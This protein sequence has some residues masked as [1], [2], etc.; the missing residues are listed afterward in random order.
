MPDEAPSMEELAVSARDLLER[1]NREGLG[2]GST[3]ALTR[4]LLRPQEGDYAKAFVPRM[5]EALKRA[6]DPFW[7]SSKMEARPKAGQTQVLLYL[8]SSEDLREGAN[9]ARQFPGGYREVAEYLQPGRVWARWKFVRPG[10]RLGMAFD[11]LVW[12]DDH[13]AWFPKPWRAV[14]MANTVSPQ[15]PEA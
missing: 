7:N 14:R 1:L 5:A 9:R 12:I 13:W 8:A 4:E 2:G 10:E 6:Y 11:G 15:V 3:A